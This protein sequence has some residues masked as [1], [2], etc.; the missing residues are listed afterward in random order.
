MFFS[1]FII[2]LKYLTLDDFQEHFRHWHI[3]HHEVDHCHFEVQHQFF[4]FF[5]HRHHRM[6]VLNF[7]LFEVTRQQKVLRLS[8]CSCDFLCGNIWN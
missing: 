3:Q 5:E 4:Q 6:Q 7:H 2:T 1:S 8:D